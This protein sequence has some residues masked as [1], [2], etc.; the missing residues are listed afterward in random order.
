MALSKKRISGETMT[1]KENIKEIEEWLTR[2]K[3]KFYLGKEDNIYKTRLPDR[4]S[5]LQLIRGYQS[6]FLSIYVDRHNYKVS[7]H[8]NDQRAS[9]IVDMNKSMV[10]NPD[11]FYAMVREKQLECEKLYKQQ[12]KRR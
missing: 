3:S 4:G 8:V 7:I 1:L 2:E 10:E 5:A 11:F 9:G 12:Q 6:D